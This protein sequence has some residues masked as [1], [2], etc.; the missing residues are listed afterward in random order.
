MKKLL[1]KII[2]HREITAA[3]HNQ[4]SMRATTVIQTKCMRCNEVLDQQVLSK[5]QSR[6]RRK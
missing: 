1:C 4:N 6:R 2:G 5:K 3:V